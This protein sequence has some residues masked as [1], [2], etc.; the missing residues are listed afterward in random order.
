MVEA[1]FERFQIWPIGVRIFSRSGTTL[2]AYTAEGEMVLGVARY[3]LLFNEPGRLADF[4]QSDTTSNLHHLET[5]PLF[6]HELLSH[7]RA[8]LVPHTMHDIDETRATVS[9]D[10]WH[11]WS[12]ETSH[13]VLTNF[14]LLW[15]IA[16]TTGNTEVVAMMMDMS[17]RGTFLDALTLG[18]RDEVARLGP[19]ERSS[20]RELLDEALRV[21]KPRVLVVS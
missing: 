20:I 7:R 13:H 10:N 15:D 9:R 17:S 16:T 19:D 14:N 6:R 4:V 11:T 1:Y 12:D 8:L 2:W 21:L 5:Y 3:A 18:E